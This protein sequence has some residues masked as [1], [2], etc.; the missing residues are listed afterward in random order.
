MAQYP[1]LFLK[2][3]LD[4]A[5]DYFLYDFMGFRKGNFTLPANI[6][7]KIEYDK[8]TRTYFADS[9]DYQGIYTASKNLEKLVK[10]INHQ[11]YEYVEVPRERFKELGNQFTPSAEII[12]ELR[13]DGAPIVIE[14]DVKSPRL[15]TN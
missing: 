3:F 10:N 4:E 12:E 2:Y 9:L 15:A 1:H 13:K 8:D 7:V 6:R 11:I 14:I 5:R